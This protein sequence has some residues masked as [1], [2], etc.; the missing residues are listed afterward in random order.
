MV[1][2]IPKAKTSRFDL[3]TLRCDDAG[4]KK[5]AP[6]KIAHRKIGPWK[7]APRPQEN[8]P[9]ESCTPGKLPPLPCN[10]S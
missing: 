10:F 6:G 1:F 9:L 4:S 5:N 2:Q 8:F 7:T 3:N